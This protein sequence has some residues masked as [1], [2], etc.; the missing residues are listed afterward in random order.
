MSDDIKY[1]VTNILSKTN[2]SLLAVAFSMLFQTGYFVTFGIEIISFLSINKVLLNT[3][4][5]IPI[6]ATSSFF[7]FDIAGGTYSHA[8]KLGR[9]KDLPIFNFF[10]NP[11]GLNSQKTSIAL[12]YMGL[13]LVIVAS[14]FILGYEDTAK[15]LFGL[16]IILTV[17]ISWFTA[18]WW[19]S[20]IQVDIDNHGYVIRKEIITFGIMFSSAS[21]ITGMM[22]ASYIAGINCDVTLGEKTVRFELFVSTENELIGKVSGQTFIINKSNVDFLT[23]SN[24][25]AETEVSAPE[26]STEQ[27]FDAIPSMDFPP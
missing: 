7:I 1:P 12:S 25:L 24:N 3:A 22:Y 26:N 9:F 18:I 14:F 4:V 13:F 6:F 10:R 17:F 11:L 21:F 16:M 8:L 2:L 23:C 27:F 15:S 5:L 19:A 20:V